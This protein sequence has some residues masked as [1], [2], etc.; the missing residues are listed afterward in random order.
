M[1]GGGLIQRKAHSLLSRYLHSQSNIGR[2]VKNA[3]KRDEEHPGDCCRVD[4][5]FT[6][7]LRSKQKRTHQW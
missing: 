6:E 1:H 2:P 3:Q 5:D 7:N 4:R